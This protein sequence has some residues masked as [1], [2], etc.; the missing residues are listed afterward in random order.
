MY[1]ST[2]ALERAAGSASAAHHLYAVLRPPADA[3]HAPVPLVRAWMYCSTS[4]LK[5]AAG[6]ASAAYHLHA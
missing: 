6:S 1:C 3:K 2:A 4:A 5:R